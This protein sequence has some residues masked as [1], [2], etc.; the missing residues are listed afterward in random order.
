MR[1][2][3]RLREAREDLDLSRE[4][5]SY[6]SGVSVKQIARLESNNPP[7]NPRPS[8]LRKLAAALGDEDFFR[9]RPG[10]ATVCLDDLLYWRAVIATTRKAAA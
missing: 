4:T 5:L 6:L 1:W 8:T 7:M 10:E 9:R 2:G 3:P